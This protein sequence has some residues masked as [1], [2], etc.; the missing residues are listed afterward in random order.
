MVC[1]AACSAK[2]PLAVLGKSKKPGCFSLV[3]EGVPTIAY[4]NQSNPWFTKGVTLW[5]INNIFW[6]WRVER[7]GEVYCILLLDNCSVNNV[8]KDKYS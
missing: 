7:H 8:L 6:P 3:P 5:W 2:C 4:T 1:T